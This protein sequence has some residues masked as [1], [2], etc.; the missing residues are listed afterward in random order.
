MGKLILGFVLFYLTAVCGGETAQIV[1]QTAGSDPVTFPVGGGALTAGGGRWDCRITRKPVPGREA[2][3]EIVVAVKLV[4]GTAKAA[5]V[6]YRCDFADWDPTGYVFVPAAV[7]DG[8]RFDVLP[9]DYPPLW[10]D[11]SQFR[12]DQPITI[13]EQPRLQKNGAP[14]RIELD[15]GSA[16]TPALGFRAVDGRGFLLLTQQ[17]C[18]CGNLGLT[19]EE[20]PAARR[21]R[22]SV[23]APR[24]RSKI[25]NMMGFRAGDPPRDWKAGDAV[26][27]RLRVWRFKAPDVQTLFDHFAECRKELEPS[28]GAQNTLPFS[29]AWRLLEE[30]HNA[31]NWN[32]TLGF[33]CHGETANGTQKPLYDYWQLGWVSG[34]INTLAMLLQGNGMSRERTWKTLDF[35]FTKTPAKSGFWSGAS[36]GK[37]FF[38]DG[39]ATP[40]PHNLSMVRKQADGLAFGMKQL[41]LLREQHTP[42][43]P[44]WEASARGLADAFV[45]LWDT[46]GQLG[47]FIDVET[48]AIL[49]GGSTAGAHAPAGLARAAA[50]FKESAYLRKAEE[51]GRF[52]VTNDLRRGVTCGGPGEIL[53]APDSESAFALVESFVEL[54]QATG[55]AEW[56]QAAH[57]AV[58]QCASWVV[59]YDYR[60]PEG[61]TLAVNKIRSTGAVWANVQNKHG[62]PAICAL[63]GDSL[64]K[65]WRATGDETA[66]GL[67]RD[68]ARGAPQYLCRP[69]RQLGTIRPGWMCERVNL[70]DWEGAENVGGNVT[71][72]AIWCE[73]ALMLVTAELPGVYVNTDTRR[74]VVFDQ[75]EAALKG[76]GVLIRN[77]T[78]YL[79]RVRVL[80]EDKAQAARPLGVWTL[81]DARCV[82][83]PAGTSVT[84]PLVVGTSTKV[85]HVSPTGSDANPGTQK[86]PFATLERAREAMRGASGDVVLQDGTYLLTQPFTLGPRDSGV[87]YVAAPGATPVLT[88]ARAI[89]G[90]R[91]AGTSDTGLQTNARG[92]V[93]FAEIPKGWRF[94]FLYLNG[95]PA[96]RSRSVNHDR[97]REW[98]RAFRFESSTPTGQTVV[99]EDKALLRDLPS[100]GD[101]ELCVIVAQ[102]GVMGGG[103]MRDF[104][105][106]KGTGVWQSQQGHLK[107]ARAEE[108]GF[109]LE[110]ALA[111][112]DEPGEWAVDSAAGRVYYWPKPGENL[113]KLVVTAPTLNELIRLQGDDAAQTVVR[114]V[115]FEGLT[116]TCTD[117]LPEDQWPDAWP[118]RQWENPGGMI[119][120]EGTE[121]CVIRRCRL[122]RAGAYGVS[123]LRHALGN[124][125]EACE[126]GWTGSGGV[127]VFGFGAGF[128]DESRGNIIRRNVIHNQGCSIYWHSPNI[129][130]FGSGS[131]VIEHNL[132]AFS[133]YNN[134][135]I[136]GMPWDKLNS[137][138]VM[139]NR[140]HQMAIYDPTPYAVAFD[141]YPPSVIGQLKAGKPYFTQENY[142]ELAIH[143]RDNR[144]ARNILLE[145]H[146]R[147]EEG[148]AF[149]TWCPGKGNQFVGN[150]VYKSHALPG[151]SIIS[152][153]DRSEYLTI[154][155]N[156][157]WC[158]GRA[159]CGTIGVRAQEKGNVIT[160]NIRSEDRYGDAKLCTGEPGHEQFDALCRAIKKEVDLAGGWLGNPDV[161]ALIAAAQADRKARAS[162]AAPVKNKTITQWKPDEKRVPSG[163]LGPVI[164]GIVR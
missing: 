11:T 36:D 76:E 85:V 56:T 128:R 94:H 116:L 160:G 5:S 62:A 68:I 73:S 78:P 81:R 3:E 150:A 21:L 137:W 115:T 84:C 43:P 31:N 89:R 100:N 55:R 53:A 26:E 40:H 113:D 87:R 141:G 58:R 41:L 118:V 105:P 101:V 60:F 24:L 44:A 71:F 54:Q 88:S 133:A 110:N 143:S 35:M 144:V 119:L 2:C 34:G 28:G 6:S 154:A 86:K 130:I 107:I 83:V 99:F 74:V 69:D 125:V 158:E 97:W 90:W 63:S 48:G 124:V 129:Q 108:T 32:G 163:L 19:I 57:A 80:I 121:A 147:L 135:S 131:N 134:I 142:R 25:A 139:N 146:T 15:T 149:Y 29:E 79:A 120:M 114:N 30:K 96:T 38:G 7:Y 106:E 138:W 112:L 45:R 103:V 67:V 51:I 12:V 17:Q 145:C 9:Q 155:D 61:S 64:F 82:E 37:G 127:Q 70:C 47:E 14:G 10:R 65:L 156:V 50:Y 148:G 18:A 8:N 104:D 111:L 20:D 72:G 140:R 159:G 102:Y 46:Y 151:S 122:L 66:L 22:F 13:T 126:I 77:P 92:K 164:I 91:L 132:L 162:T 27:I 1:L 16:A 117:R 136:T 33:Y 157:V 95:Q 109:R 123:M 42:V 152:L 39:F 4:E 59:S 52:F 23:T 153:D 75:V 49:V 93:R 161:A 98:G